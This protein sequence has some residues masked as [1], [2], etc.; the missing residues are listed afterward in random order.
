MLV[1][2]GSLSR[3]CRRPPPFSSRLHQTQLN[4][5]LASKSHPQC[6]A[7]VSH[8]PK[9]NFRTS[10]LKDTVMKQWS[11]WTILFTSAV[12]NHHPATVIARH[13][14]HRSCLLCNKS[15]RIDAS[16]YQRRSSYMK[17]LSY[18]FSCTPVR[19]GQYSPPMNDAWRLS[20]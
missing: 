14:R 3:L 1:R 18:P 5:Y 19:H 20:I 11:K 7:C 9:P 8:G 12:P 2:V 16:R 10:A 15:G 4:A 13:L 17:S 6:L